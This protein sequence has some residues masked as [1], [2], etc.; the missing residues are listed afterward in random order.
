MIG[1]YFTMFAQSEIPSQVIEQY[2]IE[3]GLCDS[4][5]QARR[6]IKANALNFTLESGDTPGPQED[7]GSVHLICQI[8]EVVKPVPKV[9]VTVSLKKVRIE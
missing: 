8:V 5:S 1:K 9:D 7:W 6:I 2:D 3:P 4:V